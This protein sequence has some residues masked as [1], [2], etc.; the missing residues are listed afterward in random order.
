M[1][2]A[3]SGKTTIASGLARELGWDF[4]DADS[5]HPP[6][7]VA[8]MAAGI[9]LDDSDRA[10]WLHALR[11]EIEHALRDRRSLALACSALKETYRSQLMIDPEVRLVYLQGSFEV[12]RER[13]QGRTGHF[14]P[15]SLLA[16]QLETLEEPS[17]AI[18]FDVR[19]PAP[20]IV[21]EIRRRLRLE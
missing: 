9:P 19:A 12:L 21:A 2:V 20:E 16:S 18:T 10:P 15:D 13:L 3:G 8:K 14:M 17:N 11:L 6:A 4:L 5:F 7:N 1:G